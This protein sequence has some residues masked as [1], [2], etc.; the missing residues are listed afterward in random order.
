MLE[1]IVPLLLFTLIITPLSSCLA[2]AINQRLLRW[3]LYLQEY[4]LDIQHE[5]GSEN[6]VADA[7]FRACDGD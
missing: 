5:K 2:C 7:L 1:V 6:V 3:S 4:N